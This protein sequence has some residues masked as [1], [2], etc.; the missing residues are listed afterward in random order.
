MSV[1]VIIAWPAHVI[2]KSNPLADTETI[3]NEFYPLYDDILNECFPRD[4]FSICPQYATPLAQVG[5]PGAIN[6]T[7][8]YVVEALDID[9]ILFFLEI[10]PPTHLHVL[11][12]RKAADAHETLCGKR[13]RKAPLLLHL[14][15]GHSS[16]P[17]YSHR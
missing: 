14:R 12:A 1:L 11:S 8:T 15:H 13:D 2:C 7:I 5:G 16:H 4:K 10:K 17:P 3:E 6:F 9:S